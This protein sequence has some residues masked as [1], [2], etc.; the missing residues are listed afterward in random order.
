MREPSPGA[1]PVPKTTEIA[2]VVRP[3]RAP[4]PGPPTTAPAGA[5]VPTLQWVQRSAGNAAAGRY[6][7]ELQRL[8]DQGPR[9][10]T[11]SEPTVQRDAE[12]DFNDA[13]RT[14][15]WDRVATT[16]IGFDDPGI[17][18][19]VARLGHDQLIWLYTAALSG[20]GLP[21][22]LTPITNLDRDAAWQACVRTGTWNRAGVVAAGFRVAD[23]A[24]RVAGLTDANVTALF[25]NL[26]TDNHQVRA[27]I[28][29]R[30]YRAALARVDWPEVIRNLGGFSD[31]DI[32]VRLRTL[33]MD[34]A[35]GLRTAAAGDARIL[36]LIEIGSTTFTNSTD[37]GNRYTA[38]ALML[39]SGL[40]ITKEVKFESVGTFTPASGFATL[41]SRVI[42]QT[43]AFLS[44]KYKLR[45][46]PP[47]GGPATGDG[48]YPI[49]VRVVANPS[50]SYPIRLHGGLSGRSGVTQAGG[51]YYER[52]QGAETSLPD[53]TIGHEGAHMVLGASDEYANAS[54]PGRVLTDDH[55]LMGNFYTQ[56]IAAAEIKSRHFQFLVTTAAAW[57]PGR[58]ISIV[59]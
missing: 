17:V 6:A 47:G 1:A 20:A 40:V 14:G 51:D 45:V 44:G 34:Q 49:M 16:L 43:A 33:T 55:S 36:R 42:A 24:A 29:D 58:T 59:R 31:D 8:A 37:T 11:G 19:H 27:A 7:Q 28:L 3:E 15:Q 22:V 46:G 30:R 56:G 57:F 48:D 41:Q 21:R 38:S 18:S 52:G 5:Q 53:I 50:A 12:Q 39:R 4:A 32:I 9:T 23:I 35:L 26:A 2:R 13:V 25:D 10:G 54:V